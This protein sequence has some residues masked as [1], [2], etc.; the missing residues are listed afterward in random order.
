MRALARADYNGPAGVIYSYGDVARVT[1]GAK[2]LAR[3]GG[4]RMLCKISVLY[5]RF[6]ELMSAHKLLTLSNLLFTN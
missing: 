2:S 1:S 5:R 3:R 6:Q 4:R